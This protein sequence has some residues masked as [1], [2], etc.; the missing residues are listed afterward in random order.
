ME[1]KGKDR[2]RERAGLR[3]ITDQGREI[4]RPLFIG[5]SHDNG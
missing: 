2:H 4:I 5:V 3:H 1:K